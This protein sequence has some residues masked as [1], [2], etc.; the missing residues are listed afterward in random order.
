MVRKNDARD[1]FG[2]KQPRGSAD[3]YDA[4]LK[5]I[6]LDS[7]RVY[8]A[9]CTPNPSAPWV[10]RQARQLSW[11]SAERAERMRFLIRDWDQKFTHAFDEDTFPAHESCG[12]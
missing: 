9:G 12:V 7:R 11:T 8:V 6:E 4:A 1:Y 3:I 10:I 2:V 5:G